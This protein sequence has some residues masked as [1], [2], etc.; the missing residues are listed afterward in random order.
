MLSIEA[1]W[2]KRDYNK[3]IRE[4]RAFVCVSRHNSLVTS[5]RDSRSNRYEGNEPE[6]DQFSKEKHNTREEGSQARLE[7]LIEL[8]EGVV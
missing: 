1:L 5:K 3:E 2:Q 4:E 6:K 7:E 8:T